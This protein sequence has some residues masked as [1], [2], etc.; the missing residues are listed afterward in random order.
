[1]KALKD[2]ISFGDI[3]VSERIAFVIFIIFCLSFPWIVKGSFARA[4]MIQFLIFCLYGLGWNLIGGYGGQ[5]ALGQAKNVGMSAY[6]VAMLMVWW[7][8]PFWV[9]TPLGVIVATVESFILGYFLFRLRGH[10]FAI[11]TIAVSLVWQELFINWD[12]VGG[13]RGVE[14]PIKPTPNFLYMQFTSEVYYHY[15]AFF[16]VLGAIL[17]MNWFRKSKLG[18]QL[19][20]IKASEDAAESL[21]INIHWAK[22][23]AYCIT[24]VFAGVGGAF[25]TVYYS[26]IDPFS[27]MQLKLSILIA[28]MTMIGGAGSMWGPIIGAMILIPLDRYLGVWLGGSGI[29]GV[30]YMIYSLIVMILAAY[31]PKGIWGIIER[32]RRKR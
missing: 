2:A 13:A 28:L 22:V 18:Y 31:E 16:L 19:R 6:T 4:V 17:F 14:L 21:G 8:I 30:D 3:P 12:L 27:V 5:V 32:V 29:L 9:S 20:A 23:K 10:Y 24:G 11:A 25:Y 26:Y 7:D 15:F 1:M